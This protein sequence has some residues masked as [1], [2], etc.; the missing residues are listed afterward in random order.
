[1]K[2]LYWTI[3]LVILVAV[4]G[5][6]FGVAG[7]LLAPIVGGLALVAVVIWLLERKAQHKPPLE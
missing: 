5:V 3:L 2:P 1:M 6:V 7:L 4:G